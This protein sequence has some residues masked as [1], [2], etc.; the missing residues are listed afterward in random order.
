MNAWATK[1]PRR[2]MADE[3]ASTSGV[4]SVDALAYEEVLHVSRVRPARAG[5][6]LRDGSSRYP[7]GRSEAL[8]VPAAATRSPA[9]LRP[10]PP[11][12][13]AAERRNGSATAGAPKERT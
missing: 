9:A 13:S 1:N 4:G 8:L 12:R 6:N 2:R 5:V 10:H 11:T 3:G 7:E